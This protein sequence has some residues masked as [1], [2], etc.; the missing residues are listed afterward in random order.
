MDLNPSKRPF[1]LP[2]SDKT[3]CFATFYK[4]IHYY[5]RNLVVKNR[6]SRVPKSLKSD[7]IMCW[8][9]KLPGAFQGGGLSYLIPLEVFR[10]FPPIQMKCKMYQIRNFQKHLERYIIMNF[11]RYEEQR[12]IL[13]PQF[14]E[15]DSP[16]FLAPKQAN[17]WVREVHIYIPFKSSYGNM[18]DK[19]NTFE[20]KPLLRQFWKFALLI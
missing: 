10:S 17:L 18:H 15:D 3:R 12:A 2:V 6:C 9:L 4:V 14:L 8:I 1:I 19:W 13:G 7:K 11:Q 16:F 20:I 5:V